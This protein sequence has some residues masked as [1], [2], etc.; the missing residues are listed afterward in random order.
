MR[1]GKASDPAWPPSQ[2]KVLAPKRGGDG[3]VR[4]TV[5]STKPRQRF[6]RSVQ[7]DRLVDLLFVQT[8]A[9]DRDALLT[10][11]R[12]NTSLGDAVASADLLGGFAGFVAM[13]D[14]GD[15]LGGQ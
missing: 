7:R 9:A 6:T 12:G 10:E 4:D 8:L 11:D 2:L 1:P 14:V 5:T 13:H 3:C 15:V